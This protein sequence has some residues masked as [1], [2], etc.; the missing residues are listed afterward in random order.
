MEAKKAI[1]RCCEKEKMIFHEF[2]FYI[3]WERIL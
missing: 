3:D 1:Y 2:L